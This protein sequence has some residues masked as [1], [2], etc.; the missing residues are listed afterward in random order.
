MSEPVY[1]TPEWHTLHPLYFTA[2]EMKKSVPE[3]IENVRMQLVN[4]RG[5]LR[6]LKNV[7]HGERFNAPIEGLTLV[8]SYL[9]GVKNEIEMAK[10][11]KP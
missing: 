10:L 11:V 2:N 6:D 1:G 8:I 9:Y 7:S 4:L 3:L 5:K